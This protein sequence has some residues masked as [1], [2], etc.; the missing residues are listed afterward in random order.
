[1]KNM[2]PSQIKKALAKQQ[3]SQSGLARDL[4]RSPSLIHRTIKNP[5]VSYPAA[6]HIAQAL[7]KTPADVWPEH[8]QPGQCAPRPGRPLTRGLFHHPHAA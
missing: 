1:M 6:K 4:N 2:T 3:V 8:F 5:S 7:G